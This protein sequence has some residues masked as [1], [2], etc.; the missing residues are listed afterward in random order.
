MDGEI[1]D[2]ETLKSLLQLFKLI[3]D[4]LHQMNLIS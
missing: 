3:L 1:H 4:D 2:F